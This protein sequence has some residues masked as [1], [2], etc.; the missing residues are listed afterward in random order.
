M[1]ETLHFF[2]H[3]TTCGQEESLRKLVVYTVAPVLQKAKPA[4]LVMLDKKK[5]GRLWINNKIALLKKLRL[6]CREL[7]RSEQSISLLFYDPTLLRCT[8]CRQGCRSLLTEL[9]YC[10]T[11]SVKGLLGRLESRLGKD[12]FPHEIGLFLGYPE[13][14]VRGFIQCKGHHYQACRY[15]KVYSDH[16]AALEKFHQLDSI[17]KH[18]AHI[19][20]S[21][22]A[23]S[24][25]NLLQAI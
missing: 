3:L 1:P 19:L 22:T 2:N 8:L 7:R 14:D 18:A 12:N 21:H 5:F 16:K 24:A 15:W 10:E 25:I 20:S 23:G 11:A 17:K 13:D 6:C 4:E 9:G